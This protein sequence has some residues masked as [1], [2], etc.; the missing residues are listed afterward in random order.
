LHSC[1]EWFI[2]QV[3][4]TQ[5]STPVGGVWDFVNNTGT[6]PTGWLATPPAYPSSTVWVSTSIINS[7]TPTVTNWSTPGQLGGVGAQG[8]GVFQVNNDIAWGSSGQS[9][10]VVNASGAIGLNTNITGT[11]NFGT[12]GQVLT[13]AGSAATPTWTTPTTGTVAS[14]SGTGTVNGLTL[15]GTV[16]TSGNLTLGG[17]LN[18]SS[19]PA[20]GGTTPA[21]G[22]FT[23]LTA[24]SDPSFTSTGAVQLPSGTTAQQPTGVA[25]KLRFNTTTSQFEGYNGTTWASV[26]GAAISNDTSTATAVYPL[27]AAATSGTALTVYTSNSSYLYTPST[28]ELK[29]KEIVATNGL[30]VNADSVSSNYTVASGSNALSIGPLTVNSGVTLTIASGQKHVII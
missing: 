4:A 7:L 16:T 29:A 22:A 10:H 17:T 23:T 8:G 25:G 18:L 11:S 15:T 12:S 6:P 28:G 27:F 2:Y 9:A 1:F 19:P 21:G 24:S 30:L 14:V 20:I 3:A 13:S 5:P 26:G